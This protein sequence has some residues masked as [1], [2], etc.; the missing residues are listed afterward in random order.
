MKESPFTKII[1]GIAVFLFGALVT[2]IWNR[3][4][5]RTKRLRWSAEYYRIAYAADDTYFGKVEVLYNDRPV[6]NLYLALIQVQNENTSDLEDVVVNIACLDGSTLLVSHGAL[7]GSLQLL[8]LTDEFTNALSDIES[9]NLEYLITRRDYKI[10]V[11]NRGAIA[12]FTILLSRTD[13]LQPNLTLACDHVGVQLVQREPDVMILGVPRRQALFS[14]W[15]V[16]LAA[17]IALA[18]L[19][20]SKWIIAVAAWLLGLHVLNIGSV[21]QKCWKW[22]GR[23]LS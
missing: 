12:N 7:Q 3:Y 14:G 18:M 19:V 22:I 16:T 23:L 21:G 10:P 6:T 2:H 17:S 4:R 20:D 1:V 13:T 11:L 15:V 8:P 9:A 5:N